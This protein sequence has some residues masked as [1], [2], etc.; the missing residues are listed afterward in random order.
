MAKAPLRHVVLTRASYG[1]DWLPEANRARLAVTAGITAASLRAQTSQAWR[2]RILLDERDELLAERMAVF[3]AAA[4]GRVDF[5]TWTPPEVLPKISWG[6]VEDAYRDRLAAAMYLDRRWR[7]GFGPEAPLIQSRID[8]DDGFAR[9]T[10]ERVE[11]Y[12]ALHRPRTRLS[13]VFPFGHRAWAG[14]VHRIRHLAN[15]MSSLYTP[16]GD[17]TCIYDFGHTHAREHQRVVPVDYLPAWLWARTDAEHLTDY[18]QAS[19]PITPIIRATYPIDWTLVG[20][21][22]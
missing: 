21:A 19:R 12:V 4:P 2:W 20:A 18:R 9:T 7:D 14:K 5:L 8:D 3:E 6:G 13:L 11:R 22:R 17:R 15:A 1:P 16:A 10:L